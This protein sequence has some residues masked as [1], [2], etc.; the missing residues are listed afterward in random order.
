MPILETLYNASRRTSNQIYMLL[1][2]LLILSQ[3]SSFNAS[4]HKLVR[5]A[6]ASLVIHILDRDI[7]LLICLAFTDT[8]KCSMVP[9]TPSPSHIAWFSGGCNTD[10]DYEV[11]PFE[12]AGISMEIHLGVFFISV[13]WIPRCFKISYVSVSY[14]TWYIIFM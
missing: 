14:Q 7:Y 11:Q 3:D 4:I 10:K 6:S 12:D 2:I 9:G 8:S 1:I 13:S 5:I